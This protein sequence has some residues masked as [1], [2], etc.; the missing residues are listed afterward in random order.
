MHKDRSILTRHAA[1]IAAIILLSAGFLTAL[2]VVQSAPDSQETPTAQVFAEALGQAN[3]RGGPGIDYPVVGEITSGTPY[4]VLA[5]HAL[6]PWTRL[7]V[8]S[9]VGEAWVYNDL[10]SISGSV[11]AVPV[12][13]DYPEAAPTATRTPPPAPTTPAPV[14][15][16]PAS[17]SSATLPASQTAPA[18]TI[19]ATRTPTATPTT[20]GAVATT[21]GEVNVRFGPDVSYPLIAELPAG[22][23][24]PILSFHTL[25]PWI[26]IALPGSPQASGWIYRDIVEISGDTSQVAYTSATNV[27][28]PTLTPTPQTVLPA[29]APWDDGPAPSGSLAAT[30]GEPMHDYLLEQGFAPHTDR[31]ASAFVLDLQT[32]DS[33][34]LND[35][36]AYSGMSLTK[37]PILAAFFQRHDGPLTYDE[38]FLIADTMMCSE[39]ITT[40]RMLDMIGEGDGVQGALRVTEFMRRLGLPTT[41]ITSPF[42][43]SEDEPLIDADTINTGIDQSSTNPDPFNQA[44]PSDLGWLLSGIYQCAMNETGLLTERYPNDFTAHECRQMLHAMDSNE[45]GV[46]LEAGVPSNAQVI[47]KHGWINDTHGDAGIVIGPESAYVFVVTLYGETWVP[48]DQTAPTIGELSR[49]AWNT[50]NPGQP[51]DAITERTVPGTCDPRNDP[52]IDALRASSLPAPGSDRTG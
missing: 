1:I 8:P 17:A 10:I 21:I 22:T 20:A 36:V 27:G 23:S 39:N 31:I 37:I 40:N 12:V 15:T 19:T 43:L 29:T 5:R 28:F 42:R 14:P 35:N 6:V 9:I 38:A 11:A 41:F 32:G 48:F 44:Q 49:M 4:V 7:A 3:L 16:T 45:I 2:D 25:V 18:P 30:L 33:F 47:H 24:Y 13:S 51:V 52:V 50:F 26:E 34:T 46:F